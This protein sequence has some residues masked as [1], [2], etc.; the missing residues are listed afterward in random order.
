MSSGEFEIF[1]KTSDRKQSYSLLISFMNFE[2]HHSPLTGLQVG[3]KM[4]M[5][6]GETHNPEPLLAP[7]HIFFQ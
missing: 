4:S 2:A 5:M 3:A 6:I 1:I 7:K